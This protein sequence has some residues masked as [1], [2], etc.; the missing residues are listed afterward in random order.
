LGVGARRR[1]QLVRIKKPRSGAS[2]IGGKKN[3]RRLRNLGHLGLEEKCK[4]Q[5]SDSSKNAGLRSWLDSMTENQ[6]RRGLR[7]GKEGKKAFHIKARKRKGKIWD[8][9]TGR[10]R[11]GAELAPSYLSSKKNEKES[12]SISG[13]KSKLQ[14]RQSV[15]FLL[16]RLELARGNRLKKRPRGWHWRREKESLQRGSSTVR[17]GAIMGFLREEKSTVP[18]KPLGPAHRGKSGVG[19]KGA[20]TR[21]TSFSNKFRRKPNEKKKSRRVPL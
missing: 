17:G 11:K 8:F 4:Y 6:P 19:S 10:E 16:K 9:L 15:P 2:I 13:G 3:N 18:E 7:S 14:K 21:I 5:K 12:I 1:L 20:Q